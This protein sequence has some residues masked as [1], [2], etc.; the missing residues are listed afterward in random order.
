MFAAAGIILL[1]TLLV[2]KLGAV[3][4]EIFPASNSRFV[5]FNLRMPNGTALNVMDNATKEVER[6]ME[7]DPRVVDVASQ[8]GED[9]SN[10]AQLSVTLQAGT[11]RHRG[12][13]VRSAMASCAERFRRW[14]PRRRRLA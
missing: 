3:N 8:I 6:R 7:K 13:A 1:A 5:R 11:K 9:S 14:P 12:F 2:I 4:T 10:S